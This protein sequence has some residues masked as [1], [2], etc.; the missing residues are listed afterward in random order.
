M[1]LREFRKRSGL[2]QAGLAQKVGRTQ[3]YVSLMERSPS[4]NVTIGTLNAL[5]GAL[6]LDPA[7]HAQLV[8][9]FA[10]PPSAVVV[11]GGVGGPTGAPVGMLQGGAQ[12]P[13]EAA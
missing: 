13:G 8:L 12:A 2:T 3:A 4:C 1:L 7:E 11:E 5:A 10:L 6:G 9:S